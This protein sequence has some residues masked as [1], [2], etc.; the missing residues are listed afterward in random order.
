MK[1]TGIIRRIDDLGRFIIPKEVRSSPTRNK[2][3]AREIWLSFLFILTIDFAPHVHGS[4]ARYFNYTTKPAICQEKN[5][6]KIIYLF[7]PKTL[8]KIQQAWY[9]IDTVK[10]MRF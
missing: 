4:G 3:K 10:E 2:K 1:A 8:D 5:R 7:F 9:T 6:K